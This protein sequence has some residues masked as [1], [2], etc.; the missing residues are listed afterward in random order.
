[1]EPARFPAQHMRTRQS[2]SAVIDRRHRLSA[3]GRQAKKCTNPSRL[4]LRQA[5]ESCLL[6]IRLLQR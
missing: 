6:K 5:V 3:G 4:A 2:E 1:V